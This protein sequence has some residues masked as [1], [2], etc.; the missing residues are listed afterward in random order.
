MLDKQDSFDGTPI[1][2][3]KVTFT[4]C[5][6]ADKPFFV[7]VANGL[8]CTVSLLRELSNFHIYYHRA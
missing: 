1:I 3:A 4:A 8:D 5:P 7:I 6:C 2:K